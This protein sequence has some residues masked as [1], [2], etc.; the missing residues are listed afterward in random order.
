MLSSLLSLVYLLEIP[1]RA[2]F[3]RRVQGGHGHDASHEH[4]G[5]GIHEAPLPCVAA[6]I[7]TATATVGL[8][9]FPNLF[10]D[11]MTLAVTR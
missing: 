5:D 1:V 3:G 2:F 11:L 7:I 8:F 10:Y 9:F 6:M 4:E